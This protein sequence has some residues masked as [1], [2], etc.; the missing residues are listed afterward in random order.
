[1][2]A[3]EHGHC[4][5]G[6]HFDSSRR[7]NVSEGLWLPTSFYAEETDPK[8]PSHVLQFKAINHVWGYELKI[9][10][11]EEDQTAIEVVG[12]DDQTKDA[13]TNDVSPPRACTA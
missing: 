9:P 6:Y 1:M 7:T 12:A 2:L 5:V 3:P 10:A 13:T 11:P 8:S 4:R